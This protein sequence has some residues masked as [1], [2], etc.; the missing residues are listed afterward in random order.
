MSNYKSHTNRRQIMMM[1]K[2]TDDDIKA[3]LEVLSVFTTRLCIPFS[4]C[5]FYNSLVCLPLGNLTAAVNAIF[6]NWFFFFSQDFLYLRFLPSQFLSAV[7]VFHSDMKWWNVLDKQILTCLIHS[8]CP[9][10]KGFPLWTR[11]EFLCQSSSL[12]ALYSIVRDRVFVTEVKVT[13][14]NRG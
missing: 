10:E 5:S 8:D 9:E 13:W 2:Q 3:N 1:S 7:P 11:L 6:L 4:S 14:V 12:T